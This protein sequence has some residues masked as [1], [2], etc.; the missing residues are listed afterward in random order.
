MNCL[1]ICAYSLRLRRSAGLRR[2]MRER[3]LIGRDP[4]PRRFDLLIAAVAVTAGYRLLTRKA[5]DFHGI[6]A[7]LSLVEVPG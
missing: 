3:S 5:A 4:K 6:H 2:V 1:E 7:A